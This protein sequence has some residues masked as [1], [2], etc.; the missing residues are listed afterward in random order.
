MFLFLNGKFLKDS[1]AMVS[2][3]DHGFLFGDGVY[4]TLRVCDGEIC[5]ISEH[6]AR[7]KKSAKSLALKFNMSDSDVK[8][9]ILKLVKMNKLADASVKIILTRGNNNMDFLTCANPTV[10]I[11]IAAVPKGIADIYKKGVDVVTIGCKRILPEVKTMNLLP[12]VLGQRE[13]KRKRVFETIFVD[14]KNYVLEG[15]V[16]NVF[17]VKNGVLI[18]PKT[19]VLKGIMRADVIAAARRLGI[20]VAVRNF[21]LKSLLNADEVF[22][23]N[24]PRGVV[25][26]NKVNGK[27]IGGGHTHVGGRE[28]GLKYAPGS[29]TQKM[30]LSLNARAE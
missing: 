28:L 23:T 4:E 30:I 13:A 6:L 1:N 25:P 26:V 20:P 17:I 19:G 18:T 15:T 2:V 7:L 21:T 24:A 10:L 8:A 12:F 5:R 9:K 27:K 11:T 16:T 22:V 14:E 3:Y 29:V